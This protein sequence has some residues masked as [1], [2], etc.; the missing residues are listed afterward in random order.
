MSYCEFDILQKQSQH[1]SDGDG[2]LNSANRRKHNRFMWENRLGEAT[3]RTVLL[4]VSHLCEGTGKES[5][6]NKETRQCYG[7]GDNLITRVQNMLCDPLGW[8]NDT[9]NW[10]NFCQCPINS[11]GNR[12]TET[13]VD[14]LIWVHPWSL[15]RFHH[16]LYQATFAFRISIALFLLQTLELQIILDQSIAEISTDKLP[17]QPENAKLLLLLR[18]WHRASGAYHNHHNKSQQLSHFAKGDP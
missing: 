1:T 7:V 13:D 12:G 9:H 16:D 11:T 8:S 18:F 15:P 4:H 3:T 17:K 2:W 10:L 5:Q 6:W 14:R